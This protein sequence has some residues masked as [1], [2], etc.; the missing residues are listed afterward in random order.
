MDI[1]DIPSDT[2]SVDGLVDS[3]LDE[4]ELNME[5]EDEFEEHESDNDSDEDEGERSGDEIWKKKGKQRDDNPFT[6]DFGPNIPDNVKSPLEIFLCLFPEDMLDLLVQQTNKYIQENTQEKQLMT[7]EELLI[8]LGI[9]ILMGIKK[10]LSYRDY[11][12]SDSK[13][14]DPF[15]SSLM[16]VVRFGFILGNLH[17]SDNSIEPKK[18]EQNYDK[19]YKL[20]PLLDRLQETLKTYW[21]PSKYQ[22]IDES[23]IKFKGRSSLKQ[24]LPA[25][26]IKRGYKCWVRADESSY[27]CE[28]QVYT[29]KM[30]NSEK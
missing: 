1:A 16:L 7:K 8:F 28:F 5:I 19:L 30:Q 2:E 4:D 24:Y 15:I 23:M 11:W 3:D 10:L 27:V 22:S 9:N 6:V 20:R 18:G 26:S 12:S 29:G 25:K 17:I 21:K 13:L 14:N